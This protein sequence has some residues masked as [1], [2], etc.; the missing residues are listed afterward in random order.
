MG[1]GTSPLCL[2]LVA[3]WP[4][5]R[6]NCSVD[7]SSRVEETKIAIRN[8]HFHVTNELANFYMQLVKK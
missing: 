1:E 8:P 4:V 7:A 6:Q 5:C 3:I 2:L